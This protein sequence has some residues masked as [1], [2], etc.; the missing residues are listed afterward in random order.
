MRVRVKARARCAFCAPTAAT[1]RAALVS[2]NS[3]LASC[4]GEFPVNR[5]TTVPIP[6]GR[7]A[8]RSTERARASVSRVSAASSSFLRMPSPSIPSIRPEAM[9]WAAWAA[10]TDQ[11]TNPSSGPVECS[12]SP[13]SWDEM[14]Y[15]F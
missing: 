12:G 6:L 14:P 13:N 4:F 5:T 11:M 15:A 2:F 7:S 1:A 9:A 3:I 10:A 8:Q